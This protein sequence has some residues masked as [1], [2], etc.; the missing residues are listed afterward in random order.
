MCACLTA[1]VML[2]RW[3]VQLQHQVRPRADAAVPTHEVI[4]INVM[5]C[6][7]KITSPGSTLQGHPNMS[8]TSTEASPTACARAPC[9]NC[10]ASSFSPFSHVVLDVRR[11]VL[12]DISVETHQIST[13]VQ[14]HRRILHMRLKLLSL[15]WMRIGRR[16]PVV[17]LYLRHW[18]RVLKQ[19]L[20]LT[21]AR[22][23]LFFLDLQ[24]V[25]PQTCSISSDCSSAPRDIISRTIS[26][27]V[28]PPHVEAQ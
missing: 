11:G 26:P 9:W 7:A 14:E 21:F 2:T 10:A 5:A 6:K 15:S 24:A 1:Y 25:R 13:L 12:H 17:L 4:I 19:C 3:L 23:E 8:A 16:C 20:S 27:A 22:F 18:R 28:R